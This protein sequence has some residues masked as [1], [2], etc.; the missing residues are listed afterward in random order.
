DKVECEGEKGIIT[1]LRS[2]G[3]FSISSLSGEKISDSVKYTKLR[4][5]ERAK[6]LMFERRERATCSWL[7]PRVSVARFHEHTNDIASS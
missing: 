1:G 4:L 3:Y 6:T 2:S 5:I 7:K